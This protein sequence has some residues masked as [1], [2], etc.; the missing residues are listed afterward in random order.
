MSVPDP[1]WW[2]LW[3]CKQ[4]C[5]WRTR[6]SRGRASCWSSCWVCSPADWRRRR[7]RSPW[8]SFRPSSR[9]E[10]PQIRD[11]P[12]GHRGSARPRI[13]PM[14]ESHSLSV[15]IRLKWSRSWIMKLGDLSPILDCSLIC[16]YCTVT[17][18]KTSRRGCP[19]FQMMA[20]GE[21]NKSINFLTLN[22][23]SLKGPPSAMYSGRMDLTT[24][25]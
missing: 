9:C 3:G 4:C 12:G 21:F 18:D 20:L 11:D 6:S 16:S 19:E 23:A 15:C 13:K 25:E 1:T 7:W 8:R 17:K 24:T 5:R 2:S 10:R 22:M 14:N